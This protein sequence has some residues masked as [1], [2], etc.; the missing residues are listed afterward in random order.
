M[1]R[2]ISASVGI[3]CKNQP[4]DVK[5]IQ[6]LLNRVPQDSGGPNP[7][8][9]DD[10]GWGPKTQKALQAFQLKQFG[11]PGADGKVFPSGQTLAALNRFDTPGGGGGN[12]GPAQP[13]GVP[14]PPPPANVSLVFQIR[15]VRC[16]VEQL[17]GSSGSAVTFDGGTHFELHDVT[18]TRNTVFT[19]VNTNGPAGIAD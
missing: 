11:W 12:S 15:A 3:G 19:V 10:G 6:Q 17:Q 7:K 13:P 8:L 5:T 1:A 2:T 18:N 9:V 16:G 14:A 4:T